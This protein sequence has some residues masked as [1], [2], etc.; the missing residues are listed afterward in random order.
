MFHVEQ[1]SPIRL[2]YSRL[3]RLTRRRLALRPLPEAQNLRPTSSTV[4]QRLFAAPRCPESHAAGPR[5][6]LRP[7]WQ[8]DRVP[9]NVAPRH[10][11]QP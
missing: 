8:E 4:G 5:P 9:A 1:D 3:S 2:Q 11:R 10:S 6:S 7:W